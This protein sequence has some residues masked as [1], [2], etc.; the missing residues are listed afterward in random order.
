MLKKTLRMACVGFLLGIVIGNVIAFLTGIS[1][2]NGVAFVSKQLLDKVNGSAVS[3]M[4][5]QS[6][7][8]G[9]YGAVCFAGMSFYDIEEMSL[10]V[11]TASHCALIILLYIPIALFL[12]WVNNITE[13]LIIAGIQMI[14]F[15]I[16]WLI[17]FL[18]YKKRVKELNE[19][20][21]A[22]TERK[23]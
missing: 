14:V 15:F 3:A 12:G 1:D 21:K 6:L 10:A 23:I 5:L 19:M 11:A 16:I 8:S 2:T 9:L 20:Q 13:I 18:V 17:M 22:F 4:A 7:F